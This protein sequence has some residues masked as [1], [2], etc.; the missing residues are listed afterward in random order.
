MAGPPQATPTTAL[1][2][3]VA[4]L[5][6]TIAADISADT[7]N[8]VISDLNLY[9]ECSPPLSLPLRC[10]VLCASVFAFVWR[11]ISRQLRHAPLHLRNG[12]GEVS[13]REEERREREREREQMV[14]LPSIVHCDIGTPL[15]LPL[16]PT[17]RL[18]LPR[19]S[20]TPRPPSR[21]NFS[22]FLF[23]F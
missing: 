14:W 10:L 20:I 9:R 1:G 4:S 13:E 17:K 16:A 11:A 22:W 23:F 19:T 2:G 15:P 5:F 8:S 18:R 6:S 3:G 7:V 21:E 12:S